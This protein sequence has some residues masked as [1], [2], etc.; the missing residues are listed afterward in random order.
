MEEL[1]HKSRSLGVGDGSGVKRS[2]YKHEEK[3]DLHTTWYGGVY[4][5]PQC[6]GDR[7]RPIPGLCWS[8]SLAEAMSS[9]FSEITCL[10]NRNEG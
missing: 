8:F 10:K 4:L 6:C 5:S 1:D 2:L 7:D 3:L 9:R